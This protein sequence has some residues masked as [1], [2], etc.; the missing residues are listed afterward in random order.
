MA[1][2]PFTCR[3]KDVV[4]GS[5]NT[6]GE[7]P[8]M[9]QRTWT[10]CDRHLFQPQVETLRECHSA[11]LGEVSAFVC[12][13]A[14]GGQFLLCGSIDIVEDEFSIFL[15]AHHDEALSASVSAFCH[16]QSHPICDATV[17]IVHAIDNQPYSESKAENKILGCRDTVYFLLC[18][19]K[20]FECLLLLAV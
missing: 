12:V 20:H 8:V 5:V 15:V 11:L 9:F 3:F 18:I 10:Q 6:A 17:I 7:S 14:L 19:H 13:D 4:K 2:S 16:S 1:I